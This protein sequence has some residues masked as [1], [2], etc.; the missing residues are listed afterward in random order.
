MCAIVGLWKFENETIE[1]LSKRILRY[2]KQLRERGTD[3]Y[4]MIVSTKTHILQIKTLDMY[5]TVHLFR[6]KITRIIDLDFI[7]L[8]NRKATLGRK[9]LEL[10]HPIKTPMRRYVIHNGTKKSI[11]DLFETAKSDTQA[12]GM[13]LD[14]VSETYD[15][16]DDMLK[17]EINLKLAKTGVIFYVTPYYILFH[18]DSSRTLFINEDLGIFSTLPIEEGVW[19]N[20]SDVGLVKLAHIREVPN[21]RIGSIYAHKA[22]CPFCTTEF[23]TSSVGPRFCPHCQ[24]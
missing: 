6:Q 8:H 20:V 10:A 1:T 17:T 16:L 13:L 14:L 4:G 2:W 7:L 21:D 3:G 24:R 11:K 23:V 19:N 18:K 12:I 5:Q 9:T 15:R 22:I